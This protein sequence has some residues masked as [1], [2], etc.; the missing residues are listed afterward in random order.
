MSRQRGAK[1]FA[2]A[3]MLLLGVG[4]MA[5]IPFLS[6]R[7]SPNLMNKEDALTGSQV[8]R[9]AYLNV[10]SKDVGPDPDWVN[11][12]Y[13]GKSLRKRQEREE[14]LRQAAEEGGAGGAGG[15]RE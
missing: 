7:S 13:V 2:T 6:V 4:G 5:S 1:N 15:A 8:M 9:G 10:S 12:R 14:R 3:A 11:G